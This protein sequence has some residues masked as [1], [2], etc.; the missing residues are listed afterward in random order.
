[1][2]FS[3][4]KSKRIST[5]GFSVLELLI[6]VA[7]VGIVSAL[8]L[9]SFRKSG[10]SFDLSGA[11]R[12]LSGYLQKARTDSISRHAD[13]TI[14]AASVDINSTSSYTANI[15]FT[16]DGTLTARTIDLP[17]GTSLGYTL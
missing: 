2:S 4:S 6:L 10:K 13:A 1:M 3:L 5:A 9:T 12:N 14:V 11:T 8:A 17:D 15:D 16:G 7:L